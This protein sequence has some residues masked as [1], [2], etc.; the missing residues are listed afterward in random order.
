MVTADEPSR[1]VSRRAL[2]RGLGA[3]AVTVPLSGL[4]SGG[5]T[6]VG[7]APTALAVDPPPE[8][9]GLWG[10]PFIGPQSVIAVHSAM[11]RTG[12]VLLFYGNPLAALWEPATGNVQ[13]VDAPVDVFC[14]GQCF[15]PDGRLLVVGG[16]IDGRNE[17]GPPYVHTFDPITALWTRHGDMRQG[18]YYPTTTLM[19]DGKVLITNGNTVAGPSVLNEDL[20]VFDPATNTTTLV[21]T[22]RIGLYAHQALLP[23]GTVMVGGP[24]RIDSCR[25]NPQGW[26]IT[27]YSSMLAA[28]ALGG[29]FLVPG[30]ASGSWKM[31]VTGGASVATAEQFD[32][33]TSQKWQLKSPLPLDRAFM[34]TV[35]L[36]D[37]KVLGIG[38]ESGV[39]ASASGAAT[40]AAAAGTSTA[41]I[42][43]AVYCDLDK[44]VLERAPK[45]TAGIP[46]QQS[47][48]YDP[49][50]NTWTTMATQT[51]PRGYHTSAVLLPDGRVLSAG[52]TG[53]TGATDHLEIYS[54]PYLFKGARPVI[55]SAPAKLTYG[56]PFIIGTPDAVSRVVLMAP[57]ANTHTNDM[58]QRHVELTFT[59]T[60]GRIRATAPPTSNVAPPSYYM[61]FILNAAG[62]PSVA[63]W[64]QL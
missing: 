59:A 30:P 52:G 35:L 60:T 29:G 24:A 8:V 1:N 28:H 11:L 15:L 49:A 4:L 13:E 62:V 45:L 9:A 32:P 55:T 14:A 39:I 21:G 41:P 7:A 3:G 6:A 56:L 48:M 2:L 57:G 22:K 18:R 33:T 63:R 38:G 37:G 26:I 58:S 51:D 54:P 17:A 19:G 25:I 42:D 34:C 61:L 44:S 16:A 46:Q 64:V 27:K 53:V 12:K 23:D 31:M 50:A 47:L 20:E 10:A 43:G 5:S 36:P 40:T